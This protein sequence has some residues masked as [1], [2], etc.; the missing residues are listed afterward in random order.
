MWKDIMRFMG[1]VDYHGYL[2]KEEI[3]AD[4]MVV[5]AIAIVSLFIVL[6]IE[7]VG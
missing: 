1:Y 3:K 2:D 4:L 5:G 7:V 6:I